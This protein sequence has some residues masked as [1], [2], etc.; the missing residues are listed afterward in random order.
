MVDPASKWSRLVFRLGRLRVL[1]G[2]VLLADVVL[3]IPVSYTTSSEATAWDVIA[4]FGTYCLILVVGV[5]LS[6]DML[7]KMVRRF[8][9][10]VDKRLNWEVV[11]FDLSIVLVCVAAFPWFFMR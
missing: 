5:S 2:A 9:L 7:V 8:I 3:F 6:V 11:L 10:L 1:V 4:A